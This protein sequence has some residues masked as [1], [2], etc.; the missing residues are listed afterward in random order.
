MLFWRI[1]FEVAVNTNNLYEGMDFKVGRA[2][3]CCYDKT[4]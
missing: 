2:A 3:K 4:L 1:G